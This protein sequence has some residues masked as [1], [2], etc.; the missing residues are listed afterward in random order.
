LPDKVPREVSIREC[1]GFRR[2]ILVSTLA[3]VASASIEKFLDDRHRVEF[4]D[5][6]EGDVGNITTPLCTFLSYFSEH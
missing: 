3:E 5:D 6:N 4:R 2:S 1:I